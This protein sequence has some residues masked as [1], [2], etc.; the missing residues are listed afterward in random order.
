MHFQKPD[1]LP[2]WDLEGITEGAVRQW[3][4]DGFPPG[5]EVHEFIPFDPY[6]RVPLSTDPIPSFVPRV[7][8]EDE[9]SITTIDLYGFQVK[10]LKAHTVAPTV[11][12]YVEGSVQTRDDWEQM[13]KRYD[14]ADLRRRPTYWGPELFQYYRDTDRPVSLTLGWG[15]GRGSKNGYMLGL[16]RFLEALH[17]E[18]ALIHDI[19]EFWADFTVELVRELVENVPVDFVWLSED[20]LAYKNA[21]LISPAMYREFWHPYVKRVTDFLRSHGVEIIGHYTSGNIKPLIPSF[22]EAGINLLGPLEC[23]AGLD[24]VELRREYGRDLLMMGNI[25]REVLMA[26]PEAVEQEFYRKVPRLMEEGG[27][28]PAVDDMILPDISF[29][30]MKRYVELVREFKIK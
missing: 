5:R 3:C 8:A 17:D 27:Y 20:G 21:T 12:Y 16:E 11:Y 2:V 26:G 23:A 19:F 25:G 7:I 28:I 10:T 6:V 1:R 29:A 13:K 30:A 4:L 22:L 15:P 14:P 9:E 24:A 18:P